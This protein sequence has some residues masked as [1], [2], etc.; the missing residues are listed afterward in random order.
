MKMKR[1]INTIFSES[2]TIFNLESVISAANVEKISEELS[3]QDQVKVL[4]LR[5]NKLGKTNFR[6]LYKTIAAFSTLEEL[7]LSDNILSAFALEYVTTIIKNTKNLKK[8][9]L[10]HNMLGLTN[11]ERHDFINFCKAIAN[12]P[13]LESLDLSKNHLKT[14]KLAILIKALENHPSLRELNISFCQLD[15][16]GAEVVGNLLAKNQK[17]TALSIAYNR[18]EKYK[19]HGFYGRIFAILM[20]PILIALKENHALQS[21]DLSGIKLNISELEL[22]N[23]VLKVNNTLT[24]IKWNEEPDKHDNQQQVAKLCEEIHAAL[25]K[26]AQSSPTDPD[27]ILY[28]K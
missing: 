2:T 27:N 1:D 4:N 24:V 28:L 7:D 13:A 23:E 22:L 3:K 19:P 5:K 10:A 11:K 26:N 12:H 6:Q 18:D 20:K 9:N 16:Y 17:L 15:A 8:L 14:N 25:D 21:L